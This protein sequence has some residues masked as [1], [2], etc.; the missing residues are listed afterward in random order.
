MCT[1]IMPSVP[2]LNVW[3]VPTMD[4]SKYIYVPFVVR[5][6][7][8]FILSSESLHFKRIQRKSF[9]LSVFDGK[10]VMI[11]GVDVDL[12]VKS[13]KIMKLLH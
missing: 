7:E 8:R 3:C 12:N 11:D 6:S 5:G 2:S 1:Q 4:E 13:P 10:K 9:D